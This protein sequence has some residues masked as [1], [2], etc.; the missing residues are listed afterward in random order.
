MAK[1]DPNHPHS[2]WP[3]RWN[4]LGD[5]TKNQVSEADRN[6]KQKE[7]IQSKLFSAINAVPTELRL[8]AEQTLNAD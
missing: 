6:E 8:V 7:D 5:R 4:L 2:G 1:R 3:R